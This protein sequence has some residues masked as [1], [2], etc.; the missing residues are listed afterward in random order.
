MA[1]RRDRGRAG[2]RGRESGWQRRARTG[3]GGLALALSTLAAGCEL[4]EVTIVDPEDVVVAEAHLQLGVP[5]ADT[6]VPGTRLTVFL[7]RT[8]G[9]AGESRPVEG[10]RV[11]VSRVRDGTTLEL[12]RTALERCV[13]TTPVEGTGSCYWSPPAGVP[14][15]P[16]DTLDL[17]IQLPA[18]GSMVSRSVVPG[19]FELLDGWVRANGAACALPGGGPL[20]LLWAPSEG[21]WAY[22]NE[23]V[24][25]DLPEALAPLGIQ[26][27]PEDDPLYLLGL[28][29]SESDT[30]IVF[31]GEFGVFDR[32]ELDQELALALQEGLP[33]PARA[34]V[35]IAA[36]DRNYVNWVRGGSFN[37]S[38]L[39]RVPSVAGDGTGV[40]GTAVVRSLEVLAVPA[41]GPYGQPR[42]PGG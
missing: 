41:G 21:A 33:V 32:F 40:W 5:D 7:H 31:P 36:A 28:S 3:F 8:L 15:G 39:V 20:D 6:G 38:G 18:G 19:A 16:G 13:I 11:A 4:E 9:P 17:S 1:G 12:A 29:I 42:C 30:T 2:G 14:F 35:T 10:A 26:V 34:E 27:D 22:V 23:T 24:I 37:P 25:H